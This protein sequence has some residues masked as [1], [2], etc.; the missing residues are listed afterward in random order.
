MPNC[1]NLMFLILLLGV[2]SAFEREYPQYNQC[3]AKWAN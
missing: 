3:D 1:N 2:V